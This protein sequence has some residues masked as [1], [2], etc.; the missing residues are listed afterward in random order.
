MEVQAQEII[1]NALSLPK[2]IRASLAELLFESLDL[3]KILLLMRSGLMKYR[4]DLMKL[5]RDKLN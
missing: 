2:S 3:Q 4:N 5:I 1:K